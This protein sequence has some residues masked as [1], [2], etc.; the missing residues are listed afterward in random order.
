MLIK[1]LNKQGYDVESTFEPKSGGN[2]EFYIFKITGDKKRCIFA[3]SKNIGDISTIVGFKI[4]DKNLNDII[5]CCLK[6]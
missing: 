2:G 3:N 6:E 5:Q 1:Q 4:S